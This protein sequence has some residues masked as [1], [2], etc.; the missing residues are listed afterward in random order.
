MR[1]K[2]IMGEVDKQTNREEHV[3]KTRSARTSERDICFRGQERKASGN[4][5]GGGKKLHSRDGGHGRDNAGET[6]QNERTGQAV[7][8][9]ERTRETRACCQETGPEMEVFFF[10]STKL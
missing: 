5:F 1:S 6:G 3:E 9:E 7:E 8:G 2:I 4:A 10:N